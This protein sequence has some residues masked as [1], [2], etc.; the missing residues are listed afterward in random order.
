MKTAVVF[1]LSLC[2]FLLGGSDYVYAGAHDSTSSHSTVQKIEKSHQETLL[3][4][5]QGLP[6]VKSSTIGD[7]KE[8]FISVEDEDDDLVSVRKSILP[9]KY[10]AT[11]TYASTL[12]YS[13]AYFKNRLPFCKHLSYTSS[14]KYILQRVLKI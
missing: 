5:N 8:D 14:Y 3:M 6:E 4:A 1:F 9:A 2:F 11:L 12:I 13:N 7:K 10:F